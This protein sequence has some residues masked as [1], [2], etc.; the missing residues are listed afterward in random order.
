[1]SATSHSL[2]HRYESMVR[3]LDSCMPPF[4]SSTEEE[5]TAA[6]EA[7]VSQWLQLQTDVRSASLTSPQDLMIDIPTNFLPFL[8]MPY[9]I[10][11][12]YEKD[13]NMDT[14]A[15]SLSQAQMSY[16][17]FLRICQGY[18]LVNEEERAL[19]DAL[20][21]VEVCRRICICS[22]ISIYY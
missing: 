15:E 20:D 1:M 17:Q 22:M 18:D 19:V 4:G 10:G 9:Y 12:V 3:T 6:F 14:R 2:Y 13:M 11:K 8:Y 5:R 21:D 7:L 16:V